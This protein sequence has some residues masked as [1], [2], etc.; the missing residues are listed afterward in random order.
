M[1]ANETMHGRLTCAMVLAATCACSAGE[2]RTRAPDTPVAQLAQLRPT[3][4]APLFAAYPIPTYV[5]PGFSFLKEDTQPPDGFHRSVP[6]GTDI[7]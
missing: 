5:P 1:I 7:E 2:D 6:F 3:N 4:R